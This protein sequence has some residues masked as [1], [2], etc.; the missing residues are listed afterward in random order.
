MK[1]LILGLLLSSIA[2]PT[3]AQQVV[4]PPNAVLCNKTGITSAGAATTQSV[5]GV[6]NQLINVC[7]YDAGA[8]AAA[9]GFQL[10]FGTGATCTTPTN[11]TGAYTLAINGFASSRSTFASASSLAGQS[12]CVISTGTG[13]TTVT[14]YYSQF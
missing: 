3:A 12:L 11:I 9:G 13:P 14:V 1:K 4:G 7:G 6:T 10:V 2:L 8:G 5:V